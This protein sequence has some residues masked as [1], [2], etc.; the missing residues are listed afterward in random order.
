M[1]YTLPHVSLTCDNSLLCL[2]YFVSSRNNVISTSSFLTNVSSSDSALTFLLVSLC[3]RLSTSHI[4][5]FRWKLFLHICRTINT[6]AD[7]SYNGT[8]WTCK[9]KYLE[10]PT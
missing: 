7:E 2:S 4:E 6:V 10:I 3:I 1:F 5:T 8:R 9:D